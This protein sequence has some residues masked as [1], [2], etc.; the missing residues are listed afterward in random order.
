MANAGNK[1][2]YTGTAKALHWVIVALLIAQFI[3]AWTMPEIRR[4]T[5]P[6]T[7]INLHLSF[8]IVILFVRRR[9]WTAGE[10]PDA[11]AGR[12]ACGGRDLSFF[13]P[14]RP[15]AAANAAGLTHDPGKRGPVF[16]KDHVPGN[17]SRSF[18]TQG[19]NRIEMRSFARRVVAEEDTDRRRK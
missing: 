8:G 11:G 7:L 15:R 18:V 5:K 12:P 19:F 2:G 3:V 16:G 14:P 13:H 1:L 4:D 9:A 10:L 17:R 6:E